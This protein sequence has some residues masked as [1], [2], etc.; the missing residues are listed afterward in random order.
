MP[1]IAPVRPRNDAAAL[2]WLR[3]QPSRRTNFP[4]A[5]LG[6][7]WGWQRRRQPRL[8]AWQKAGLVTRHG[9]VFT[10][11]D[12]APKASIDVAAYLAA[13]VMAGAAAFGAAAFFSIKGMVVLFP[14]AS[15]AV[16][17][18]AFAMEG[19]KLVTAGWLARRWRM[20]APVSGALPSLC[21]S[22]ALPSSMQLAFMPPM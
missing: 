2:E 13:I 20:T 15:L 4:T 8:K 14:G 10:V 9:N 16:V 3:G 7:Q 5:E 22:P 18:M 6:R 21:S 1:D 19:A 12:S 17:V 11:A